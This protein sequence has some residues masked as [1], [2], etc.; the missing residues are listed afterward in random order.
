MR[1][2]LL[3]GLAGAL[4][5]LAAACASLPEPRTRLPQF[6]LPPAEGSPLARLAATA[7]PPRAQAGQSGFRLLFAGE[8][9]F[10]TRIALARRA[11]RSI[12]A[13]YYV[14]AG[15]ATG[16]GLL[17]ELRD[18][19]SRGV[20]VRLLVDDLYAAIDDDLLAG[21][22]AHP[23]VQVRLFNPLPVRIGALG[24]RLMLSLHQFNRVNHRMHNKLF[25]ADNTFAVSGG[26]NVA[27]EYF[28]NNPEANFVDLDVL[29]AG[30][31][32]RELS[33]VFD[34]FWNSR[35]VYPIDELIGRA[36]ASEDRE[37]FESLVSG[38]TRRLGERQ[39]DALGFE[40]PW[41]QIEQGTLT[42]AH[43]PA[44]GL[45]DAPEK[46][47]DD[48]PAQRAPT[49]AQQTLALIAG[50]R[51]SVLIMSPYFIP[52]D[53]GMRSLRGLT[54]RDAKVGVTLLTNSI[55]ATDEP[56]AYAAYARY[57]LPLL[58]AGVH[59]YELSPTLA[60]DSGRVGDFGETTGRLHSKTLAIDGRWLFIGS[61]NLDP[62]SARAN[63]EAGLVI[64]SP[65]LAQQVQSVF[66]R[67]T[68]LG[69]YQ[70]RLAPG[71]HIEWI[72]T[73]WQGRRTV[74]ADEPH[75]SAW[76]RL[77]LWLLGLVVSEDL[78]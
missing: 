41:W 32:V 68:A 38:E 60:R 63:T 67:G 24:M 20:R 43:A 5:M 31:V 47:V 49:V 28:M 14:V 58:Q 19:A 29:A 26:R 4:L 57:R 1:S 69:T 78:L 13:Q 54:G 10:N 59:I 64:D 61:M 17:R 12:D 51:E 71:D 18:A 76:L 74:H 40:S 39:R 44:R 37:S 27:D 15:D 52:G 11:V 77:K 23:N 2:H 36:T 46:T 6:A 9:A 70:L 48:G 75:D 56:L 50:A 66:Q 65:E 25:I 45:S 22:A 73:D 55:G 33:A 53:E 16:R 8:T 34:G 7:A 62:R 21:L 72:E 35:R 3:H 42:M 30:P